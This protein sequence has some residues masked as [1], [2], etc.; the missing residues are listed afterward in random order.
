MGSSSRDGC[1]VAGVLVMGAGE[2]DPSKD[3]G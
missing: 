1:A 3:L 2:D